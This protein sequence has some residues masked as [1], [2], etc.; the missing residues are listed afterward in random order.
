MLSLLPG[1]HCQYH[2]SPRTQPAPATQVAHWWSPHEVPEG[3]P[4]LP[5]HWDQWPTAAPPALVLGLPP[6]GAVLVGE[7]ELAPGWHCQYL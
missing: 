5:P 4:D 2:S 7:P 6:E 3:Q 1:L